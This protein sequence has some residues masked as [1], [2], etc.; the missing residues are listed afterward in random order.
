MAKTT[1]SI[2][3]IFGTDQEDKTLTK[4]F[5][6]YNT[7]LADDAISTVGNTLVANQI[8]ADDD[9]GVITSVEKAERLDTTKT[10][11]VLTPGV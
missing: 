4:S 3:F 1:H 7:A 5:S 2:K 9:S 11:V 6:G 8:F 10:D